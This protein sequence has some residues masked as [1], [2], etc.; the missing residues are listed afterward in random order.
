MDEQHVMHLSTT[1]P[2]GAEEWACSICG[3][4]FLLQWP[5]TYK[6]VVL[7]AGDEY[8]YHSCAKGDMALEMGSFSQEQDASSVQ[9]A[10]NIPAHPLAEN[11]PDSSDGEP[12]AD[13]LPW[14]KWLSNANLDDYLS[15]AA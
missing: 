1:H 6:K 10:I 4:R 5:P 13:L 3:R 8:A 14:L 11:M 15:E 2:S 9:G 7:E 12:A